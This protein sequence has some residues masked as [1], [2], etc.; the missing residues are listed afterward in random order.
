M[1][2]QVDVTVKSQDVCNNV[3]SRLIDQ[4]AISRA[5]STSLWSTIASIRTIDS[6]LTAFPLTKAKKR[7]LGNF[8]SL[9]AFYRLLVRW[10]ETQEVAADSP[11]SDHSTSK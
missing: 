9:V 6:G 8:G 5:G 1:A 11:R 4:L 10:P 3:T 2:L 7:L